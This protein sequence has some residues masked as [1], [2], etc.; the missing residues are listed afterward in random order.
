MALFVSVDGPRAQAESYNPHVRYGAA[1]A[2][3]VACAGTGSRGAVALLEP[4]LTD[5]V[6]FVQQGALIAL[7]LV[8]VE[9]VRGALLCVNANEVAAL[10][11][12]RRVRD[13]FGHLLRCKTA[14]LFRAACT[15]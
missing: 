1:M 11:P 5:S 3:G 6:D 15:A 8:L 13:S 10:Q 14:D 9:Q 2:V 12:Q 7:A 4:M